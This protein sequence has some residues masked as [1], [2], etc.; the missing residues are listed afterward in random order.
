MKMYQK[1]KVERRAGK[2]SKRNFSV[3]LDTMFCSS[4][5][6]RGSVGFFFSP[7]P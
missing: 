7:L 5:C 1:L 6:Q 4:F 2:K 3:E